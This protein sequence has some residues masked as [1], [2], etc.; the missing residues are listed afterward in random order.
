M[1]RLV[2]VGGEGPGVLRLS[3]ITLESSQIQRERWQSGAQNFKKEGKDLHR[4]AVAG[5]ISG[6]ENTK[7]RAAI[8]LLWCSKTDRG[9]RQASTTRI[10]SGKIV[11]VWEVNKGLECE[12]RL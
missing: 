6:R 11:G 8:R 1:G 5:L 3:G 9:G 4:R 12:W 10:G 7:Q 2:L